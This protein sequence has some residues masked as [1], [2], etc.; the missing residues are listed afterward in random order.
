MQ[1]LFQ[2]G[3]FLTEP[4]VHRLKLLF[5]HHAAAAVEIQCLHGGP[6]AFQLCVQMTLFSFCSVLIGSVK[7]FSQ[8]GLQA[9]A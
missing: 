2:P 8:N 9:L 4:A 6:A 1:T 3:D 7:Y 5:L